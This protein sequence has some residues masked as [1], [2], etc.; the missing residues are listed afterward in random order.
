[1]NFYPIFEVKQLDLVQVMKIKIRRDDRSR[2][3]GK[4]SIEY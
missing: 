3:G 4:K 2:R 1:M